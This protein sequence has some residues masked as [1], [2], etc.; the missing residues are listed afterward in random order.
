MAD[1]TNENQ[2][3]EIAKAREKYLNVLRDLAEKEAAAYEAKLDWFEARKK[4]E[5]A[6]EAANSGRI[7]PALSSSARSSASLSQKNIHRLNARSSASRGLR[8]VL[9][10]Q[11]LKDAS[12]ALGRFPKASVPAL[13]NLVAIS[14]QLRLLECSLLGFL[15]PDR[16][17]AAPQSPSCLQ[18]GRRSWISI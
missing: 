1:V 18:S 6:E 8:N 5:E 9:A 4:Y 13:S 12:R 14:S 17:S 15:R 11:R 10:Q 3:E 7:N 2:S 16:L